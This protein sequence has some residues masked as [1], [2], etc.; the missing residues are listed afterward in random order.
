M[1]NVKQ[2]ADQCDWLNDNATPFSLMMSKA[3][4]HAANLLAVR[5][6]EALNEPASPSATLGRPRS[7]RE[8]T[9]GL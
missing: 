5:C 2:L 4:A 9:W 7:I 8:L 6:R 1:G 3:P